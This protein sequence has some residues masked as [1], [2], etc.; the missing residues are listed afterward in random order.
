MTGPLIG[1]ASPP[2]TSAC[3]LPLRCRRICTWPDDGPHS[4]IQ[5]ECLH[6]VPS[7]TCSGSPP[8]LCCHREH[9]WSSPL[10]GPLA[11]P[12]A[13]TDSRS[14]APRT[15]LSTAQK[16]QQ[17][18]TCRTMTGSPLGGVGGRIGTGADGHTR[19]AVVAAIR[20]VSGQAATKIACQSQHEGQIVIS[21]PCCCNVAVREHMAGFKHCV[22]STKRVDH[23]SNGS[24]LAA[25]GSE[26]RAR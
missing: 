7:C 9:C 14:S 18:H 5:S 10:K 22:T 24:A 11:R 6:V 23:R 17:A 16:P 2:M 21:D 13:D 8:C 26:P 20:G 15:W 1:V 12:S 3:A 25:G 19:P 4:R